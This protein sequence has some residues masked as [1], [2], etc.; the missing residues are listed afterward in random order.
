MVAVDGWNYA[1]DSRLSIDGAQKS[2]WAAVVCWRVAAIWELLLVCELSDGKVVVLTRFRG[3]KNK[4]D[5]PQDVYK[6]EDRERGRE[7][8]VG[9]GI[10]AGRQG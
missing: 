6:R 10:A 7:R 2:L 8:D 1:D 4:R 3:S 5:A 9:Q